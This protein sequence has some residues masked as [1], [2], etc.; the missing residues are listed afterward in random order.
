MAK[1]YVAKFLGALCLGNTRVNIHL[2][3]ALHLRPAMF[4]IWTIAADVEWHRNF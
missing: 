1:V 4:S 2:P 3:G